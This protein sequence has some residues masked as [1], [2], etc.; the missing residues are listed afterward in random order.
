[1]AKKICSH[2]ELN[3]LNQL[4]QTS[5]KSDFLNQRW[6]IKESIT[7]FLG[8]GLIYP[9]NKINISN[10]DLNNI[11]KVQVDGQIINYYIKKFQE[12]YYFSIAANKLTRI[13][14]NYFPIH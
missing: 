11:S 12:N 6:V 7:K 1:L 10:L 4:D 9:F 8:K 13:P 5:K 3:Q 14:E 2:Q